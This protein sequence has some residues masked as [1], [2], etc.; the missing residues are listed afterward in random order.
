MAR[1]RAVREL[2]LVLA[3]FLAYR[4]GRLAVAGDMA[5]A[6]ANAEHVWDLE[7]ALELPSEAALQ[8]LVLG[9]DWLTRAANLYYAWVH[10]PATAALLLWTYLRR[11]ALYR[12]ARTTLAA[13][14]ATG[15]AVQVLLP[16]APPRFL[17]A[18]GMVDTGQTVGPSVYGNPGADSL[19]NQYAA[20]PSLHVGWAAVVAIVLIRATHTRWRWLWLLHPLVTLAVV[21]VTANHYWLDAVV[22]V[23]LLAAVL[24]LVPRAAHVPEGVSHGSE[25]SRGT[26]APVSG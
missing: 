4:L 3:L 26:P 9:Q 25:P 21:V 19:A 13:L 2:L 7:R 8:S 11:P 17:A 14:T 22:A 23:A 12:W 20:M 18:A 5:T 24:P 10:F 6:Y 1:P 15:F 16:L